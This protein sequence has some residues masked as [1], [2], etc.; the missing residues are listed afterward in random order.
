[1][2]RADLRLWQDVSRRR[3]DHLQYFKEHFFAS[4]VFEKASRLTA[5]C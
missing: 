4:P 1:M 2:S 3:Q 5:D